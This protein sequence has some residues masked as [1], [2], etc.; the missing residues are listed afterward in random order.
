MSG[1]TVWEIHGVYSETGSM[2]HVCMSSNIQHV[3]MGDGCCW[4][5][6]APIHCGSDILPPNQRTV[7]MSTEHSVL[8]PVAHTWETLS[9]WPVYFHIKCC[10]VVNVCGNQTAHHTTS[11]RQQKVAASSTNQIIHLITNLELLNVSCLLRL[12]L[13]SRV[14]YCGHCNYRRGWLL[15]LVP[16]GKIQ[17]DQKKCLR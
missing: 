17:G 4:S 2:S 12:T 14:N 3:Q 7:F 16:K 5:L 6:M 11:W 10:A 13:M 8:I 15:P 1:G 9:K